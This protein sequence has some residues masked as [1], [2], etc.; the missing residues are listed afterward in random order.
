V[1]YQADRDDERLRSLMDNG[2]PPEPEVSPLIDNDVL[3]EPE[4]DLQQRELAQA[5]ARSAMRILQL[6]GKTNAQGQIGYDHER[7]NYRLFFDPATGDLVTESKQAGE[8]ILE[9]RARKLDVAQSRLTELDL[10]RFQAAEQRIEQVKQAQ[11]EREKQAKRDRG[12][13]M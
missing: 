8:V 9:G 11:Q 7:G 4:V 2:V 12:F 1:D 6:V 5:V 13:E 3:S 10:Q